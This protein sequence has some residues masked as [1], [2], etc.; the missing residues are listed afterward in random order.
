MTDSL[1][2]AFAALA[3]HIRSISGHGPRYNEIEAAETSF[4]ALKRA[5]L[6]EIALEMRAEKKTWKE[7][8]DTLGGVT[9]QRAFQIGR[10]E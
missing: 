9:Y 3:T 4:L 10:G 1:D 8:G 7:I 6:R 5:L 2:S